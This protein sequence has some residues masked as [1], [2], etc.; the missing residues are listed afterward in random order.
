MRIVID[1]SSL[2]ALVRYYLPFD[3]ENS[4]KMFIEDKIKSSEI[5]ILDKVITE[6]K[7]VAQ[8]I[9]IEEFGF[10]KEKSL[11][12]KTET[13]LPSANFIKD[14]ENRL[15]YGS[16][17]NKLTD[18]QFETLKFDFLNS[19]DAKLILCCL[20]DKGSLEIDNPILVT[21]ET[22]TDND[23]KLFKKL[24]EICEILEINHCNLPELFKTHLKINLSD[25]LK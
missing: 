17:K 24:P 25:Y 15:C 19:A 1:T 21:E 10:L 20:T 7:R 5:I 4:L 12:F 2:L 22:S 6:S 13:I 8:G 9:I 14:L 18:V 11:S 16:Q 23:K 3:K